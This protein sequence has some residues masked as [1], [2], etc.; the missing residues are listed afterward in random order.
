MLQSII[1]IKLAAM[2]AALGLDTAEWKN[3][4]PAMTQN[5][6]ALAEA[7]KLAASGQQAPA[8]KGMNEIIS[9]IK[10]LADGGDKDAQFAMGHFLR[11]SNQQNGVVQALEYYKKAADQGQLQAMNNY[12]TILATSA[13]EV[14]KA[15]EG[16]TYIKQA[17]DKGLNEARRN[18]ATIYLRGGAGEKPDADAAFKL[19]D[20]A[21]KEKDSQADFEIAQFY[22]GGG[23]PEK[24]DDEKAWTYLQKASDAGNPNALAYMGALLFGGGK[25]GDKEVQKDPGAA[26]KKFQ[27]LAEQKVPAGLRTMGEL[28]EGGLAGVAKDFTKALDFYTQAAQG[29]DAAAQLRLA[30][31]YDGGVDLTPGD[32]KVDVQRN[33]AAALQLYRLAAQNNSAPA[34]FQVATFY[35]GGRAVDRDLNKAFTLYLQSAIQGLPYG[36]QKTGVYYLNGAGTQKDPV[37]AAAWFA[38]AAAAGLPDGNLSYGIVTENGL[39]PQKDPNVSQFFAAGGYYNDAA[40]A[41]NASDA[42]RM[43]ALVRLGSLYFRGL[44]VPSGEQPKQN[45][46]RA[47]LYFKQASNI[48]PKN[49]VAA[50]ARDEAAAKLTVDQKKKA[51]ADVERRE[52]DL[53][54]RKETAATPA[55][56]AA[57]P[58]AAPAATPAAPA[59]PTTPAPRSR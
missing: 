33:D 49:Q 32:D 9:S 45:F 17:A 29:N 19:L 30:T 55:A 50:Q 2:V 27:Q 4:S 35:E 16:V 53:K 52:G 47:Y 12:G 56:G 5:V 57:A 54:R 25:I 37:S 44:M 8:G 20:T 11:Q 22:A 43:D 34:M 14:E 40:E 38:R 7:Q 10:T 23:G 36:M 48:D 18:M 24:K 13:Q 26:V 21:S 39:V 41:V 46:E 1:N 15:K 28:H 59:K 51:D 42:V 58:A 3:P 31:F 6:Q